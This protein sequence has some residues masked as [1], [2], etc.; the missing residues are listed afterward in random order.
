M[1]FLHRKKRFVSKEI[2]EKF[3]S[4]VYQVMHERESGNNKRDDLFQV[5]MDLRAKHGKEEFTD[6]VVA[7]HSMTFLVKIFRFYFQ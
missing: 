7:G 4:I 5:I 1:F 3:R 2:D 6:T